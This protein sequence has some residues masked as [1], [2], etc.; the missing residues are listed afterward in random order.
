MS[1]IELADEARTATRAHEI[2]VS[3][4]RF[5]TR[6]IGLTSAQASGEGLI[7]A[8]GYHPADDYI[9]LRYRPDG[10]LEEIGLEAPID[11]TEPRTN[12]FFVNRASEM[13]NLVIEGVRLTWTEVLV[14]GLTVKRLAR[15]GDADL[16]VVLERR[17]EGPVVID[18]TDEVDLSRHGVERFHLRPPSEVTIEVNGKSVKIKRGRRTGAEIKAAAIA[19]GVNIQMTFTLSEDLPGGSKLI[20]D[21]DHVRIKGGEEFMAIDDHDDS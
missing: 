2:D 17:D 14:T 11:L 10:S 21:T 20:G 8:L 6:S 3:N 15:Q 9:V 1:T 19:Q 5:E 16:E 18:D 7:Q 13:A 4:E 12:S